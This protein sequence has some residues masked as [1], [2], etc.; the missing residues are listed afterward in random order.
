MLLSVSPIEGV[1]FPVERGLEQWD[2]LYRFNQHNVTPDN[3]LFLHSDL[4]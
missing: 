3:T 1:G 4:L 2:I